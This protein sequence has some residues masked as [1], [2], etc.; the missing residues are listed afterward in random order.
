MRQCKNSTKTA[1]EPD[2][3]PIEEIDH[4]MEDVSIQTWIV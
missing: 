1:D 3:A 2:C 4:F